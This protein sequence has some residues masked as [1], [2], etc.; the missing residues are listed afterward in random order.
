MLRRS[1]GPETLRIQRHQCGTCTNRQADRVGRA[2][3]LPRRMAPT[4]RFLLHW[5]RSNAKCFG[6]RS[7]LSKLD[8]ERDHGWLS[9]RDRSLIR[10]C[11]ARRAAYSRSSFG[12]FDLHIRS[13][14]GDSPEA[15]TVA[16]FMERRSSKFGSL[17][18]ATPVVLQINVRSATVVAP[19]MRRLVMLPKE[20]F[21]CGGDVATIKRE[22]AAPRPFEGD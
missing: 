5:R 17:T 10:L 14:I 2:T 22:W 16:E 18:E 7:L 12:Q 11:A 20:H 8:R 3:G 21:Q 1:Q 6:M 9:L 4:D 19:P 13:L 15:S